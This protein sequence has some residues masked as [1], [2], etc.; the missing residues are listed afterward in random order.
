M[1]RSTWIAGSALTAAVALAASVA[2]VLGSMMVDS[3][4]AHESPP[5]TRSI[6]AS[7]STA[8][9]GAMDAWIA[10]FHR[11]HPEL[12]VTY[13][14]NGSDAGIRDFVAG[15]TAFAG[16][17][18]PMSPHEQALADRRCGGGAMHL[19]MVVGPIALAYNLPSVSDLKLSPATLAGIFSGRITRW[20]AP[21]IAAENRGTHLPHAGIR[22]FHHSDASGTTHNFTA[23]LRAA[24]RWPHPPSRTWS[25]AGQG[26]TGSD[27]VAEAVQDTANS[28]GYVQ[29][30]FASNARLST[31][32]IRNA[33]GHFVALS[34]DTASKAL[35][36]ARVV[37]RRD[38][39]VVTFDYL[40]E[41]GNAYPIV[42]VTYEIT[43][44][45]PDPLVQTFL[46]YTSSD[47]GQSY[48]ALHGYAPLPQ[49]L[50]VKVRARLG[51]TS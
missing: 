45:D 6:H 36:R 18:L 34:P 33:A 15:R 13:E 28:I 12:R 24:G 27:G 37:G 49:D 20:N 4:D 39:L 48:L 51:T 40:A 47:A 35:E 5:I 25:G 44:S 14:A 42:L 3:D 50:L 7:G 22:A 19:P 17:D 26:V 31:A 16:S 30:G 1:A 41:T 46:T 29:Y 9:K 2:F 43:C 38:D 10:E 32:R 21:E 23:Y 8:Q 11:V